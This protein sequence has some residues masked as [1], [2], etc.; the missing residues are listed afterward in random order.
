MSI[1]NCDY[2]DTIDKSIIKFTGTGN[3]L[4]IV[5]TSSLYGQ[6]TTT[7]IVNIGD[8]LTIY[9]GNSSETT[10]YLSIQDTKGKE[11]FDEDSAFFIAHNTY[12]AFLGAD[13]SENSNGILTVSGGWIVVGGIYDSHY[14]K[15]FYDGNY[16]GSWGAAIGS[17]AFGTFGSIIVNGEGRLEGRALGLK[18]AAIGTG[19][20][21]ILTGDIIITDDNY[22]L[23]QLNVARTGHWPTDA[24]TRVPASAAGI[25][26]GIGGKVLGNINITGGTVTAGNIFC[27]AGIGTAGDDEFT[28]YVGGINIGNA[29]LSSSSTAGEAI[30]LGGSPSDPEC[31]SHGYVNEDG[32]VGLPKS[33][34]STL[35]G[36]IGSV[37]LS[38]LNYSY[39][40]DYN[41]EI[42]Y[43]LAR[44]EKSGDTSDDAGD[45]EVTL[46]S[47]NVYKKYE[48]YQEG[49]PLIIHTGPKANL[50][51]QVFINSMH[52]IA[53]GLV[54]IS[55]NPREN[56]V[57]SL[58]KLDNALEYALKEQTKMGAYQMRLSQTEENLV[59]EQENT[60][61]AES[62]LTDAD[63][64][65]EMSEFTKHNVLS[66]AAQSMLAQEQKNAG[67]VLNMLK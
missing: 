20:Q 37:T 60:T 9:K 22:V 29:K 43:H 57:K 36:S 52:P 28:S 1:N 54:G 66:Q 5:N 67:A 12:G 56:A 14:I 3:T 17:G 26:C 40:W 47:N 34:V 10:P 15:D 18:G 4:N 64:A 13:A 59:A 62:V 48:T 65:K 53:M 8:E 33:D 42:K 49:R 16:I 38:D 27:G 55:I 51:L 24:K 41:G 50:N 2:R 44:R 30:G 19:Y 46:V 21:G 11:D 6:G 7:A 61:S 58:E 35:T 25:G 45:V 32:V 23:G 63:M 39:E 31:N